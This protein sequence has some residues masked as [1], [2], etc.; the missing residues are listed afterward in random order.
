MASGCDVRQRRARNECRSGRPCRLYFC[1]Q[2][3]IES[4]PFFCPAL[5]ILLM[6]SIESL[7]DFKFDFTI[8]LVCKQTAFRGGDSAVWK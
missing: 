5:I 4:L 3:Q 6:E 2:R 1:M 8:I 7:A